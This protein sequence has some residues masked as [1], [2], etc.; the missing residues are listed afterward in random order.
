MT[1]TALI[2]S[3]AG[4]YADPW[5]QYAETSAR[6]AAV[7]SDHGFRVQ[8]SVD[9]AASLAGLDHRTDLLVMNAGSSVEHPSADEDRQACDGLLRYLSRG[10]PVLA[11][12]SSASTLRTAPEWESV[13]GGRWLQGITMHP[14]I[15]SCHVKVYPERHPI[16]ALSSD[17]EIYDEGYSYLRVADDVGTLASHRHDGLEHPLLWVRRYGRSPIVYDALGHDQRSYDSPG[18]VAILSRAARWLVDESS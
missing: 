3:G 2:V 6:I 1:D 16:V 5:H 15:G 7:L 11:M 14:P 13:M 18:H 10:G 9:V 12:H 4:R 8:T 17:F